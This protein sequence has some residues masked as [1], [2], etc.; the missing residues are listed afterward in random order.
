MAEKK[1]DFQIVRTGVGRVMFHNLFEP[2]QYKGKGPFKW[3]IQLAVPKGGEQITELVKAQMALIKA[4]P[5]L[6]FQN[7]A[8]TDGDKHKNE[9]WKGHWIVKAKRSVETSTGRKSEAPPVVNRQ[10]RPCTEDEV[11]NGCYGN[12]ALALYANENREWGSPYIGAWL[13]GFQKV[14]DGDKIGRNPG[15]FFEPLDGGE[16]GFE[17]VGGDEV[18]VKT[19]VPEASVSNDDELMPF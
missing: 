16:A 17:V 7:F 18:S 5:K 8:V 4:N 11:Y 10:T 19:E 13:A 15:D 14:D 2:A 6:T 3:D 9:M 12:L 1:D